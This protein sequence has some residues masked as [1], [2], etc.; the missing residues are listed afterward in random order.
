MNFELDEDAGRRASAVEPVHDRKSFWL[1]GLF[2]TREVDV[3][4][5]CPY[6]AWRVREEISF[7]D[8][9]FNLLTLGIWSPRSSWYYCREAPSQQPAQAE[10]STEDRAQEVSP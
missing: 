1:G 3:S 6:G 4:Q 7:V 9:L 2:P 5:H 8:G 10:P